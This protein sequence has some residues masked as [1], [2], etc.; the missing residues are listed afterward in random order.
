MN[1]IAG[2]VGIIHDTTTV[3]CWVYFWDFLECIEANRRG[4]TSQQT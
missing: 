3:G 4:Y 1:M 2:Y